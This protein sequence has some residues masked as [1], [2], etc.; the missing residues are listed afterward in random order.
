[1]NVKTLGKPSAATKTSLD[2]SVSTLGRNPLN[3]RDVKVLL[4]ADTMGPSMSE[5]KQEDRRV[6][7]F[8]VLISPKSAS[9]DSYWGNP[10]S[11]VCRAFS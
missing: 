4:H 10:K 7:M 11:A 2:I 5:F 9:Q 3:G 1:V 6:G 8:L